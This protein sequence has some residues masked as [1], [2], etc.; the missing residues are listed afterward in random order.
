MTDNLFLLLG[1]R[2]RG[3]HPFNFCHDEGV[4]LVG[5]NHLVECARHFA[6]PDI[7]T[8]IKGVDTSES[9]ERIVFV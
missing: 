1:C 4:W 8:K 6:W 5:V 9:L 2:Q 7:M 3:I